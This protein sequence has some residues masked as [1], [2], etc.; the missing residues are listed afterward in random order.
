VGYC[1][2]QNIRE[3]I[4]NM[5]KDKPFINLI[6]FDHPVPHPIIM[7]EISKADF[8][9]I[10]YPPLPHTS[11]SVPTKLYE[12]LACQLPILTWQNQTFLDLVEQHQ[13]GLVVTE[14]YD[15]LLDKMYRTQFYPQPPENVFW[16]ADKF[17]AR[18]EKLLS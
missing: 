2:L 17:R 13:A 4:L 9:I 3:E 7:E 14:S 5:L 8:G 11:G 10:Y 18:I 16:E 15:L 6:G 12:Y 1:A